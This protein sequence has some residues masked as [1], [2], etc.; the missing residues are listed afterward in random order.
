[1][2]AEKA[3]AG[4]TAAEEKTFPL[5]TLPSPVVTEDINDDVVDIGGDKVKQSLELDL[6]LLELGL[7]FPDSKDKFA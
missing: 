5:E 2:P 7:G 1:M 6:E 4:G 3:G